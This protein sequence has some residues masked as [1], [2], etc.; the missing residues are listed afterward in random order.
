MQHPRRWGW[1][2]WDFLNDFGGLGLGVLED[3]CGKGL[4][5]GVLVENVAEWCINMCIVNGG[6]MF[7]S[8]LCLLAVT[9]FCSS[10]LR[11]LHR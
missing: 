5:K 3:V 6:C 8:A 10:V 9:C 4:K 11:L 7:V 2:G 1:D